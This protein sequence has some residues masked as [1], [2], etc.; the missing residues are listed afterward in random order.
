ME[1][2]KLLEFMKSLSKAEIKEFGRY[3]EGTSYRK[4]GKVIKLYNYLSK[5]YPE[6]PAK[7]VDKAYVATKVL[8]ETGNI[9]KK[10][11][12]FMTNLFRVLEEFIIKKEIE[13]KDTE[14]DFILL[15]AMRSRKLDKFFFQ[16]VAF[17]EKDWKKK[18]KPGIDQLHNEYR[19]AKIA[20]SHPNY[21][22]LTQKEVFNDT[23]LIEKIDIYYLACKLHRTGVLLHNSQYLATD[24]EKVKKDPQFFTDK[25]IELSQLHCFQKIPQIRLLCGLVVS[26]KE[27]SYNNYFELKKDFI[28]NLDLFDK[29]EKKDIYILISHLCYE[30]YKSGKVEYLRELFELSLFS[31]NEEFI[32]EEN[33]VS[34]ASFINII[35][36]ACAVDE[37]E[38]VEQFI[39]DYSPNLK[40]DQKED[41]VS[42]SKINVAMCRKQYDKV[43]QMLATI[44]FLDPVFATYAK[45]MQLQCYYEL[46]DNY[47]ELFLNQIKSFD[48]FIVRKKEIAPVHKIA[49]RNFISIVRD[50]DKS[51]HKRGISADDIISK[52]SK[53]N[54]LVNKTWL[55][56]KAQELKKSD[57]TDN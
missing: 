22:L 30:N 32:I 45:S 29:Y 31:I 57:S 25:I 46:G 3:L 24:I 26:L 8:K 12:D 52:I 10:M 50:L 34:K 40:D 21:D 6:F 19:L 49:L 1:K 27:K 18:T 4:T 47:F 56:T 51:K 14:R 42:L 35:N 23:T 2:S 44:K 16:K 13:K 7:K 33:Y 11:L 17:M 48:A 53:T 39:I 28:D 37:L 41:V 38:W 9:S 15:E 55:L 43:L 36:I 54:A 5:L 20:T